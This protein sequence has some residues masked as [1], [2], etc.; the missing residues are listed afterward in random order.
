MKDKKLGIL[1]VDDD[2]VDVESIERSIEGNEHLG[3][4]LTASNGLEALELLR[5][6]PAPLTSPFVIL[7]DLNMPMMN[8]LEF[9][10]TIRNDPEL[11]S[12]IVFILTT[13][14][15]DSDKRAAYAKHVAGYILKNRLD[16]YGDVL[17]ELLDCYRQYNSFPRQ[18]GK[19]GQLL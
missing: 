8:G 18:P 14:N 10:E 6:R 12:H 1:L 11:G 7:L 19:V 3:P 16:E 5:Q 9:L 13:S 2:D 17:S 4:L 15:D